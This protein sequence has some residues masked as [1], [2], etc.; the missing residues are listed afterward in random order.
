MA[1]QND[2]Y[3]MEDGIMSNYLPIIVTQVLGIQMKQ[4][5]KLRWATDNRYDIKGLFRFEENG[6]QR[7]SRKDDHWYYVTTW[8]MK[9]FTGEVIMYELGSDI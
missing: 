9:I 7:R 2:G 4:T 6:I 8:D 3:S 1:S 5:F